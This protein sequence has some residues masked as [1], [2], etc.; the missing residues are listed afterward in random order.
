M[1]QK[2]NIPPQKNTLTYLITGEDEFRKRRYLDRL[3]GKLMGKTADAFNYNLYY[4]KDSA[5][6]DVIN[7]LE[8]FSITGGNR[9]A[10]L[11]EPET[12][13]EEDR[14]HLVLYMKK[15]CPGS[16]FL[17]MLGGKPS[18]RLE[19][20]VKTLPVSV[21]RID[22]SANKTD[23]ISDWIVK[24]FE[25]SKKK[26][27]HKSAALISDAT[28]QDIGKTISVIEQVSI[29][30]GARESVTDDDI[31]F[32][33]DMPTESSTFLLL[34]AINAKKPNKALLIL[35]ELLKTE[36]NPMQMVG[37]LSWH[38]IRLIRVKRMLSMGASKAEMLSRLRMSLYRLDKLIIQ[39]REFSL[40]RLKK[41]L[42]ALSETDILIKRS[43]A[44]D[45]YLLEMLVVKLAS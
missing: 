32:F 27:S 8:T 34:D 36:S 11:I 29:F 28:K 26:I 16:A 24:E 38:I 7:F 43:N 12:F 19:S 15:P 30:M 4:A 45:D 13:S 44:R 9:M 42:H 33:L 21:A 2:T 14:R 18:A 10:A 22:S 20:F 5:A 41:D 37:F 17:V 35:K 23:D 3:K 1:P 39:A 40:S 25:K 6:S 31:M